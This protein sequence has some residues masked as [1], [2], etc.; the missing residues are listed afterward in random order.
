[1][2]GIPLVRPRPDDLFIP[3]TMIP[4]PSTAPMPSRGGS[5]LFPPVSTTAM[6]MILFMVRRFPRRRTCI[7]PCTEGSSE[8][9]GHPGPISILIS[10]GNGIC[11]L[12]SLYSLLSIQYSAARRI[13]QHSVFSQRESATSRSSIAW[14]TPCA[15][16]IFR[17]RESPS[18]IRALRKLQCGSH[19]NALF[20]PYLQSQ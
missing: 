7:Y 14:S 4:P 17:H 3:Y 9:L 1:M 13:P 8:P 18:L 11:Y 12:A 6:P 20:P 10:S 2:P 15:S 19:G 5:I 16:H